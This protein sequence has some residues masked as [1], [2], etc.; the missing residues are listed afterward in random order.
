MFN[1]FLRTVDNWEES[2]DD[3]NLKNQLKALNDFKR[4]TEYTGI[5]SK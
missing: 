2:L 3:E 1:V 5:K 4:I